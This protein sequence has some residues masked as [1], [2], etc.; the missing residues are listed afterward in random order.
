[1]ITMIADHR[2]FTVDD[3]KVSWRIW[4]S[5]LVIFILILFTINLFSNLSIAM[6]T[7]KYFSSSYDGA[8]MEGIY[9]KHYI[10]TTYD[11]NSCPLSAVV[12]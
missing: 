10:M 1:M 8:Q 12:L 3:K 4:R 5:A 7:L 2:F 9:A 6:G 11:P